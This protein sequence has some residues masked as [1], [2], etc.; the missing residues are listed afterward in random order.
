MRTIQ[1]AISA[2]NDFDGAAPGGALTTSPEGIE[3][4]AESDA[5]GLFEF[6]NQYPVEVVQIQ[7]ILGGQLTWSISVVDDDDDEI[8]LWSGTTEADFHT[9]AADRIVLLPG[10]ALKLVTSTASAAMKA[11]VSVEA[12]DD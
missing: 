9:T 2:G 3:S 11:R 1:Q 10:Q 7:I 6:G 4:Y 12:A 5:G 8:V